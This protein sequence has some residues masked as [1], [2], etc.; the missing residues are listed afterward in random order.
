MRILRFQKLT[1]CE[2]RYKMILIL[3]DSDVGGQLV[4]IYTIIFAMKISVFHFLG[5]SHQMMTSLRPKS[6]SYPF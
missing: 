2:D 1:L 5:W 4:Y 3:K 6:Y